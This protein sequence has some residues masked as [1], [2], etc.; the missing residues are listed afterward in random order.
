MPVIA[1]SQESLL[2]QGLVHHRSGQLEEARRA[3]AALLDSQPD[4][5]DALHLLGLVESALGNHTRAIR[6]ISDAIAI[7]GGAAS[8]RAN[9]GLAYQKA[10]MTDEAIQSY[11]E[12][13]KL[14]PN[15]A[16]TVAKLGRALTTQ[17]DFDSAIAV[18]QRAVE[19]EPANSDSINALA[20]A[21]AA[22]GNTRDAMT[23]FESALTLDETHDEARGNLV[24]ALIS[25]GDK[26]AGQLN[27]EVAAAYYRKATLYSPSST[28]AHFN[29]AV[30]LTALEQP[31]LAQRCYE[32]AL[33][34]D[35][36]HKGALNN[37]ALLLHKGEETERALICYQRALEIDD[38]YLDARYNMAVTLGDLERFD[39]AI[40]EYEKLLSQ[41]SGHSNAL[42]NLGGIALSNNRVSA[43]IAH[44]NAALEANPDHPEAGWNCSLAKLALGE[45]QTGWEGYELRTKQKNFPV[46][47]F[48]SERW[49]GQELSGK[50][51]MVWAEQGLGDTLQFCRFLPQLISAGATVF[52]E[53][54]QPLKVL[55]EHLC[56]GVAV[57]GRGETLP[58]T[59]YH[60]P[61]LSLPGLL[62]T[63]LENIPPPASLNLPAE[64]IEKWRRRLAPIPGTKVGLCW[65]ANPA[66]FAGRKRSASLKKWEPLLSTP[67]LT[68]F[69]LQRGTPA[70]EVY[71]FPGVIP[72]EE[73]A[74]DI[75]DTAAIISQLDLVITVD[76]MM[77][78]LAGSIGCPVWTMLP[79]A[80]DWRWMLDRA[81]S[82]WYP[83]MRLWRQ[84]K[85]GDWEGVAAR[86]AIALGDIKSE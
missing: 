83:T 50:R 32:F 17:G 18:L 8:Y 6:L 47:T 72:L 53:C 77:A 27:W 33:L 25:C 62:E 31:Q 46:R 44:Y 9:L 67:G 49:T 45:F 84:S 30:C 4:Q 40:A 41:N 54:Q 26:E 22:S 59:D 69:S 3:Y 43:A 70:K 52:L 42:N 29:L 11:Y 80:A 24:V 34:T 48:A 2:E 79:Y 51:I 58:E 81:D 14:E 23:Q 21:L 55:L 36:N 66:N 5:A 82:L 19:M 85:P 61:L 74:T 65:S 38:A 35:P 56:C 7:N 71:E 86:A 64:H 39:E 73:E 63:R 78:H 13:L 76:T 10:G 16:S 75:L 1:L 20:V 57:V 37:L 28:A 12:A 15:S 68:F 60:S